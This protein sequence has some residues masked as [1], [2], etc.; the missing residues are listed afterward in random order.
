MT[1]TTTAASPVPFPAGATEATESDDVGKPEQSVLLRPIRT[2]PKLNCWHGEPGRVSSKVLNSST[3][4][5][6][7]LIR[8]D[9]LGWDDMLTSA[10]ARKLASALAEAADDLDSLRGD[11]LRRVR[12]EWTWLERGVFPQSV[13]RLSP[14]EGPIRGH[15]VQRNRNT[16]INVL[17]IASHPTDRNSVDPHDSTNESVERSLLRNQPRP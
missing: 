5:S 17:V 15:A 4:L 6:E 2:I 1:T 12:R 9:G 14:G 11:E 8:V 7:R 10:V 16:F 3:E 13:E